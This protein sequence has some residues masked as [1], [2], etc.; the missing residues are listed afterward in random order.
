MP[1]YFTLHKL[2]SG[3]FMFD[4]KAGNH[5]VI[6]TSQSYASRQAAL[7]AIESVRYNSQISLRFE[8]R[9]A[10]DNSLYFVLSATDGQVIGRSETYASDVAMENGIR[11]AMEGGATKMIREID[12]ARAAQATQA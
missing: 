4:L 10:K 6:L 5:Q 11:S 2:L 12:S 7:D 1:A 9:V 3:Q 8:R